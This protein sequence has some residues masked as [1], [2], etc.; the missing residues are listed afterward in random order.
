[1]DRLRT[2][3]LVT[4]AGAE[5]T[6]VRCSWFNQNFSEGF[7]VDGIRAGEL[8][9][10]VGDVPEPF[11]DLEDVADVAVAA[12]TEDGHAGQ[13]YELTG[14]QL[15]RFDE[16]VATIADAAGRE[17]AFAPVPMDAFA[18][19]LRSYGESED[20]VWLTTYLFTEVLD[21]RNA[22]LADGVQRALGRPARSFAEYARR[23]WAA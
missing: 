19:T 21:G 1:M 4:Q 11:V 20:V 8:A 9:L 12:L 13:V 6:V 18:A 16:A 14:P 3:E 15:L 23:V 2:E 10:P 7:F 22:S 17:I 5:W